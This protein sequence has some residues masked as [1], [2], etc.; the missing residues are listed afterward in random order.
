MTVSW[1]RDHLF[2]AVQRRV[3]CVRLGMPDDDGVPMEVERDGDE[4]LVT[5]D[6]PDEPKRLGLRFWM[7]E[8]PQGPST[9]DICGSPDEWAGEVGWVL[10][11][12]LDTGLVRRAPRS[13]TGSGVIE[14]H[15]RR[16]P[17]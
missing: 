1:T 16:G 5:F 15:Y 13:L 14:L 11:E 12:E 4:L 7:S 10:M 2:E 17:Y 9:G 3:Q 6:W 8:A